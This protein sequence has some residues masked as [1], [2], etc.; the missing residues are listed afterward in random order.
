MEKSGPQ[1]LAA[2]G[3]TPLFDR[4]RPTSNLVRPDFEHFLKYSRVF[5]DARRYTNTGPVSVLMEEKF[6]EFHGVDHCVSFAS[7]FWGL[8]LAMRTLAL[9]DKREVVMPSFTYRRLADATYWAG[10]VPHFCEVDAQSLAATPA[11]VGACVG[12]DT[13]LLVITHPIVNCCDAVGLT[14]FAR[15]IGVPV[16]FDS[17]ESVYETVAGRRTG[18]FGNAEV[19]SLHA[20]KLVNGFE[21]GYVTTDDA[22][23]ADRLALERGFGF[24]GQDNVA[25]FGTN[26]KL[27]EVH[28]AMALAS[29]DDLDDQV[30]RNRRRYYAYQ[31]AM[32]KV[33]GLRLLEFDETE[34]TSF[35][36]IVVEVLPAWPLSRDETVAVLNAENALARAYYSPPLHAMHASY[37]TRHGDLSL[38]EA[39]AERFMNLPCGH[40]V[41]LEDV[42]SI[43]DLLAF[44]EQHG[45]AIT[46][47][48]GART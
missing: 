9:A 7:G 41:S 10:L 22:E 1:D 47:L 34:K 35:K 25:V 17:V 3:G 23:L 43:V 36:N 42:G 20:S 8:V 37:E 11:T 32:R 33:S 31:S 44:V 48:L 5:F 30:E 21:G 2:F 4:P 46:E 27:N 24:S 19:Y 15:E 14:V 40:H 18:S 45:D 28:A 13:A 26:A 39:L 12:A 38:T 16:L 6:A 29:L